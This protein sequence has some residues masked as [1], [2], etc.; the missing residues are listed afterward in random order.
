MS[1]Q[2][3][4]LAKPGY[5]GILEPGH[6]AGVVAL[7]LDGSLLVSACSREVTIWDWNAKRHITTFRSQL[8][9]GTFLRMHCLLASG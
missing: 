2:V 4:N 9:H 5:E 8:L 1:S 6:P 3:W 7:A